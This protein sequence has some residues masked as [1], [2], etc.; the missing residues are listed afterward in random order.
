MLHRAALLTLVVL[1]VL[2]LLWLDGLL[3]EPEH[4]SWIYTIE[5][6]TVG[7]QGVA[8]YLKGPVRRS[9]L[10]PLIAGLPVK[11]GL[12]PFASAKLTANVFY[13]GTLLGTYAMGRLLFG[14]Q[15]GLLAA[16]LL[17]LDS[18]MLNLG[19]KPFIDMGMA[20]L[21]TWSV[22]ALAFLA[23]HP[24]AG[25]G[26][27]LGSCLLAATFMRPEGVVFSMVLLA[28]ALILAVRSGSLS[29]PA[30]WV[31]LG[32]Y[33]TGF[34]LLTVSLP[35][36]RWQQKGL[37][38]RLLLESTV[39]YRLSPGS[40]EAGHWPA[41]DAVAREH[42]QGDYPSVARIL[43][44]DPGLQLRRLARNVGLYLRGVMNH[45]HFV[46][47]GLLGA[48]L[49]Y[50]LVKHPRFRPPA[51]AV[52]LLTMLFAAPYIFLS[53]VDERLAL[54]S[55]PQVY[56][57]AALGLLG[58]AEALSSRRAASALILLVLAFA[59]L[60][61]ARYL[62]SSWLEK[63]TREG[64]PP[65]LGAWQ[66]VASEV[67]GHPR[68][69]VVIF[70]P[71]WKLYLPRET[72]PRELWREETL[73]GLETVVEAERPRLLLL[74]GGYHESEEVH[75]F[76]RQSPPPGRLGPAQLFQVYPRQAGP[77]DV[78]IFALSYPE[79]RPG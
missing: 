66:A 48:G 12:S 76:F 70:G 52:A 19:V 37:G 77:T 4:D 72:S 44:E 23:R 35:M 49:V 13:L 54:A 9:P 27:A 17:A 55:Y 28:A 10:F 68:E 67:Q 62:Q 11:A 6:R 21:M 14:P 71:V 41:V 29:R 45:L 3:K 34:A 20:C 43:L 16:A 2:R 74:G 63:Y 56:V 5:A 51:L 31:A 47:A 78:R 61:H 42:P 39:A 59:G 46:L 8:A 69:R 30:P 33:V 50:A 24:R 7:E 38:G 64:Y 15:A 57:L 22:V 53:A 26:L 25:A 1:A 18:P 65:V 36:E 75:D 60:R 79:G 32:T 73:P 58:L 40:A